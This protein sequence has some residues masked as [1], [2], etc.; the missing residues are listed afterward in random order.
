MNINWRSIND[1]GMPTDRNIGY[2]V[3][4]GTNIEFS[5]LDDFDPSW[6]GGSVYA[7]YEEVSGTTFDFNPTHWAPA[8]EAN[9]P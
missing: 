9:L 5:Y 4:D 7:D 1:V 8:T 3:S 2:L 6:V